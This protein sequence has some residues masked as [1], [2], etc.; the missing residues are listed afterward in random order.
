[1]LA[2]TPASQ[3]EYSGL[4]NVEITALMCATLGHF[5]PTRQLFY[6]MA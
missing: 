6:E 2:P 1:M 5:V 3:L 4:G